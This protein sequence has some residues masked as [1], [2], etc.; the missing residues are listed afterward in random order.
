MLQ[1]FLLRLDI[2][3]RR[4]FESIYLDRNEV[5]LNLAEKM[6]LIVRRYRNLIQKGM[7][8]RTKI[9]ILALY[10]QYANKHLRRITDEL[11]SLKVYYSSIEVQD[12]EPLSSSAIY[13]RL[14][15]E[16]LERWLTGETTSRPTY[17]TAHEGN[18]LKELYSGALYSSKL[19]S[20]GLQ[21]RK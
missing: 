20:L 11:A 19:T 10:I 7:G 6:G 13:S 21:K 8:K 3:E 16:E 14:A 9:S 5:L 2:Q 15:A 18:V 4:S 12:E 17:L 1:D